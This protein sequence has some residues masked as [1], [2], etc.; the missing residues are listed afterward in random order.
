VRLPEELQDSRQRSDIIAEI[1][2]RAYHHWN[3]D[4][5]LQ[6]NPEN[7]RSERA[8]V[9]LQ[10]RPAGER[11]LNAGYRLQ[12]GRLEQAEASGAWPITK[13][14][15]AFGR[16]VYSLRDEDTLERFAG[17]E[18]RACCWRV[19]ALG[20]RFVSSRTGEQDTGI[21]LQLELT[22]LASVGSA[23]DSFLEGAI[24]GYSSEK[25]GN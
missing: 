3:V 11:V 16:V 17:F 7:S 8:Q 12:R 2:L 15:N 6:W 23:A 20:R 5:G 9:A 4:L 22:G 18:Y 19:R 21:Y 14:W 1:A 10:Y 24:R 25:T 13:N